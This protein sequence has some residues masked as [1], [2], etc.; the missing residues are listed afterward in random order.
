MRATVPKMREQ[1][2]QAS[3]QQLVQ[4]PRG[5]VC[6]F[7]DDFEQQSPKRQKVKSEDS[8]TA[9]SQQGAAAEVQHHHSAVPIK[10]EP[11]LHED[12]ASDSQDLTLVELAAWHGWRVRGSAHGSSEQQVGSS[13]A[14]W[15]QAG[16]RTL[17][18]AVLC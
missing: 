9:N 2:Q 1:T 12:T 14:V 16:A 10:Q 15:D 6:G 7:L 4:P 18:G 3:P 5:H 11:V 13:A 8:S 17:A